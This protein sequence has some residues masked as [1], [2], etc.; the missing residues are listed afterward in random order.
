[1]LYFCSGVTRSLDAVIRQNM[2]YAVKEM[3][4]DIDE[5]TG[6]VV[7]CD[8]FEVNFSSVCRPSHAFME[9]RMFS[10]KG[11]RIVDGKLYP[12]GTEALERLEDYG[13]R[14]RKTGVILGISEP[15]YSAKEIA[16][17]NRKT[18]ETVEYEG[19]EKTR[20]EWIQKQRAIER[21]VRTQKT[22]AEMAHAAGDTAVEEKCKA[23]IK[24][25]KARYDDL[26]EKVGLTP[27]RERMRVTKPLT[28]VGG[29]GI[30]QEKIADKPITK[31]TDE[32]IARVPKVGSRLYTEEQNA[33]IQRQHKELLEY[34]RSHDDKEVAFVFGRGLTDRK[35]YIGNDSELTFD[36][37]AFSR[38][39]DLVVMHNH[40]RNSSFSLRDISFLLSEDNVKT[41]SVV[42]NN[43]GVEML[44]KTDEFDKKQ[45]RLI[46][47]RLVKKYV[48]DPN[49]DESCSVAVRKYLEHMQK[50]GGALEWV[51]K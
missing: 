34:A 4:K 41:L 28:N 31:I 49:A 12:D 48:K 11:D 27:D 8:G 39:A 23:R 51:K 13:C 16:E 21:A 37:G 24:A 38:G 46:L 29:G 20:Y 50:K 40:P 47:D 15:R 42:K 17:K 30:M 36:D 9:G 19:E 26:T 18:S 32:A 2:L 22:T 33:E 14:H 45:S 3:Q 7:D 6:A 5:T 43:G 44:T 1:M 25:L 10:Y 35:Q